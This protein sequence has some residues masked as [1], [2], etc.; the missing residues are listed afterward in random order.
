MPVSPCIDCC[1]VDY[2][3]LT[4]SPR[5]L[6][7]KHNADLSLDV[8]PVPAGASV[9]WVRIEMKYYDFDTGDRESGPWCTLAEGPSVPSVRMKIAGVFYIRAVVTVCGEEHTSFAEQITVA[10]P[11]YDQIVADPHVKELMAALWDETVRLSSTPRIWRELGTYIRLD[12][13]TE[14]YD[15]DQL[16]YG[17]EARPGL[18]RTNIPYIVLPEPEDRPA[19]PSPCAAGADYYVADFHT[20]P[21]ATHVP[22]P[23]GT[24]ANTGSLVGPSTQDK[25]ASHFFQLPGIVYDQLPNVMVPVPGTPVTTPYPDAD[26]VHMETPLDAPAG[27]YHTLES[28]DRRPTPE[29]HSSEN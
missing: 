16:I 28:V 4:P 6:T 17:P 22:I 24:P 21:P 19:D 12:T 18:D 15:G 11:S 26:I 20:H 23:H 2:V 10:F 13:T 9:T 25:R 3:L 14:L 27:P 29:Y 8:R 1:E 5:S 7:L